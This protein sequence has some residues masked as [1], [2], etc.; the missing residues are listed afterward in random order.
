MKALIFVVGEFSEKSSKEKD[1]NPNY[2]Y[3][4]WEQ[5]ENLSDA[6]EIHNHTW[7]MHRLDGKRTGIKRKS[8][9]SREAY[10]SALYDDLVK[11]NAEVERL[12]GKAPT[13]F[14]IPFGA[15]EEWS[16]PV[17]EAAG[18]KICFCSHEGIATLKRGDSEPLK[19]VKRM[20]RRPGR[21]V[22]ALLKKF[23]D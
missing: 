12:T 6:I 9:E 2:S 23:G 4:R 8:G 18:L 10:E 15:G 14:A 3:I 13:A 19:R 17:L 7:G 20:V 21:S 22:E 5:M 1:D 16:M 11:L